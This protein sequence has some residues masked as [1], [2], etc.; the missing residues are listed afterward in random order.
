MLTNEAIMIPKPIIKND[1]IFVR[2][3]DPKYYRA[4]CTRCYKEN[5]SY[6]APV[7]AIKIDES[8]KPIKDANIQKTEALAE[9]IFAT[10]SSCKKLLQVVPALRSMLG[11]NYKENY[12]KKIKLKAQK[13][14]RQTLL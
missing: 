7:Y 3:F 8:D 4:K 10:Q 11:Q 12:L 2:S 9:I 6:T 5:S 1:P 14:T 13:T